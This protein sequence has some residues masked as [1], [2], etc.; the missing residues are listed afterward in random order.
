M[1]SFHENCQH[2]YTSPLRQKAGRLSNTPYLHARTVTRTLSRRSAYV[3]D[4]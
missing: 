1:H 4:Q 2:D 3:T